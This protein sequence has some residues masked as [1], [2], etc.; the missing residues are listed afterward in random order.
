MVRGIGAGLGVFGR[1]VGRSFGNL[2]LYQANS[3]TMRNAT[4]RE[5][6][7]ILA[8]DVVDLDPSRAATPEELD[9]AE[10]LTP[11]ELRLGVALSKIPLAIQRQ[12]LPIATIQAQLKGKKKGSTCHPGDLAHALRRR[13]WVS[14]RD[15]SG[16]GSHPTLWYPPGVC[17]VSASI[18]ARL[19]LPP[20]RPPKWLQ[21][22][23]QLAKESGYIL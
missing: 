10:R 19:K 7:S 20:G 15:W 9:L 14:R 8:S 6:L 22:A 1:S 5:A 23:R 11:V 21:R 2:L 16:D 13:G 3:L 4:A 12:G 18:A 17:P